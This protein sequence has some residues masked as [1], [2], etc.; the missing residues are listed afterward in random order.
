VRDLVKF[1]IN[2]WCWCYP[3]YKEENFSSA[4]SKT[5][6]LGFDGIEVPVEDPQKLDE[7]KLRD[8]LNSYDI[9]CSSTWSVFTRDR[10][11]ISSNAQNRERCKNHVKDNVK[12]ASAL[13]ADITLLLPSAVWKLESSL[14]RQQ[15][16]K[17]A[18]EGLRELGEFS[19]EYGVYIVVEP[20]NRFETYFINS[21]QDAIDLV[22]DVNHPNVK[23]MIDTFHMN[24]EDRKFGEE[25]EKAGELI[26]HCHMNENDRGPPGA[27]HIPFEEIINALKA[28]GY[29]RWLVMEP[30]SQASIGRATI[31]NQDILALEGLRYLQSI[32][33]RAR[34][35]KRSNPP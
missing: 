18:V 9:L 7:R 30:F 17:L 4:I 11:L 19:D 25:I 32:W 10:D 20:L 23:M 27:G 26:F 35:S 3:F 31:Q 6:T 22:K 12:I 14:T 8:N 16:W 33:S 21:I 1:G 13:D 2:G 28:I 34:G 15:E 24:I 29:D 5:K